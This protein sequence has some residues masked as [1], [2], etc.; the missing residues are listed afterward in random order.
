[1]GLR[2]WGRPS[3][4]AGG[5]CPA[6]GR[7]GSAEEPAAALG[8]YVRAVAHEEAERLAKDWPE[9][10][11][12]IANEVGRAAHR[13]RATAYLATSAAGDLVPD[14]DVNL[15]AAAAL[16]DVEGV[17]DGSISSTLLAPNL[18]KAATSAL[19]AL[20]P[21][22]SRNTIVAV[23][24][25]LRDPPEGRPGW[26]VFTDEPH[27]ELLEWMASRDDL[28]DEDRLRAVEDLAHAVEDVAHVPE[29]PN[30]L[31]RI[32]DSQ[33]EWRAIVDPILLPLAE[34]GNRDALVVM[35]GSPEAEGL[36][37]E[38]AEKALTVLTRV[39]EPYVNE[40]HVGVSYGHEVWLI[41]SLE[42]DDRIRAIE[43]LLGRAARTDDLPLNRMQALRAIAPLTHGL[44]K[45]EK[46]KIFPRVITFANGDHDGIDESLA[47]HIGRS[48]LLSTVQFNMGSSSL[49]PTGLWAAAAVAGT[50]QEENQVASLAVQNLRARDPVELADIAEALAW[51]APTVVSPFLAVFASDDRVRLRQLAA[52]V[53]TQKPGPTELGVALAGDPIA[54]VR[55]TLA[56]QLEFLMRTAEPG[57]ERWPAWRRVAE[58]LG[59]D[60]RASIRR[61]ATLERS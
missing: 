39:P 12:H 25:L 21:R 51:L 20:A 2:R 6:G 17:R 1:M 28:P 59:G 11:L 42:E 46:G 54:A 23:A 40:V 53:W 57:D 60:V 61:R 4:G 27:L 16:E 33:P 14:E 7:L 26:R 52:V 9:C 3:A 24:T 47:V 5:E 56:S 38:A 10:P 8:L 37:R 48:H 34:A 45:E 18:A 43:S 49:I 22:L 41:R 44:S 58:V 50:E 30:Y 35:A 36:V 29:L 19:A 32:V 15:I 13:Q 31:L 55:S